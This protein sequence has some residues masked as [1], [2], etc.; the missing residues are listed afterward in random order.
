MTL[1]GWL[2]RTMGLRVGAAILAMVAVLQAV[3]LFDVTG[4]ILDGGRGVG[5]VFTYLALRLPRMLV[6]AAPIGVLA[7]ALFAFGRLARDGSVT[8]LRASGL[9]GYRAAAF[10]A[11]AVLG[12][13]A[14]V[15]VLS[16]WG[17][18]RADQAVAAWWRSTEPPR[19]AGPP[20]RTFRLGSDIVTA[21]PADGSGRRL[22]DVSIYRR[23]VDGRL[24][25]RLS[26][27]SAAWGPGGWRLHTVG[28]ELYGAGEPIQTHASELPWT[29]HLDPADVRALF[30]GS[31]VV[32]PSAAR[33]ALRG[34]AAAL[35]QA[36]YR[37]ML[38][39]VWAAPAGVLVLLLVAAPVALGQARDGSVTRIT[40][41]SLAAGLLFLVADGLATA[42]GSGGVLLPVVAA[43]AAP[44][45]FGAVAATTL[46]HMEG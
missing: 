17:A 1:A 13:A 27:A 40:L 30:D 7:G 25:R 4:R 45:V 8:A 34:G 29:D 31:G 11:P 10:A 28:I 14:L 3:D 15:L 9:S 6:Q 12:V 23:A 46:L 39:R 21:S 22:A 5:A 41:A 36:V 42:L 35:P 33:R 19:A 44:V 24:L 16:A 26:A 37:T 20:R 32:A 2:T 18:P 43:W 38:A